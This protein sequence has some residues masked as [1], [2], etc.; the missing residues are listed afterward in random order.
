MIDI[1][2]LN[3]H[4]AKLTKQIDQIRNG[5]GVNELSRKAEAIEGKFADLRD[6]N[7]RLNS[8][9]KELMDSLKSLIA[10]VENIRWYHLPDNFQDVGKKLDAVLESGRSSVVPAEAIPTA[11]VGD[12]AEIIAMPKESRP[13]T[14]AVKEPIP[15]G[16]RPDPYN[17]EKIQT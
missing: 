14:L 7:H 2:E 16:L 8:E 17:P 3:E 5:L 12:V 13:E 9:N 10:S 15:S 4:A 6:E 1:G 11:L